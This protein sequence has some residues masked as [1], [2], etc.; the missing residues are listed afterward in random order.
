[1]PITHDALSKEQFCAQQMYLLRRSKDQR[2]TFIISMTSEKQQ[3]K[4]LSCDHYNHYCCSDSKSPLQSFVHSGHICQMS[5]LHM[6]GWAWKAVFKLVWIFKH[7]KWQN[8]SW[9]SKRRQVHILG[10][11]PVIRMAFLL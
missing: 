3:L 9:I 11:K 5:H 10:Y 7:G 8:V 2:H 1:M 6:G 4:G